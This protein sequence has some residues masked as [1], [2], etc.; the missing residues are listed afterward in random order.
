MLVDLVIILSW[1]LSVKI[2]YGWKIIPE[3]LSGMTLSLVVH[4][5]CEKVQQLVL[6]EEA[7]NGVPK[8]IKSHALGIRSF[9][10]YQIMAYHITIMFK[11][12]TPELSTT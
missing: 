4:C 12:L 2:T 8:M 1:I 7:P 3:S 6:L 9:K 11:L 10:T 5:S